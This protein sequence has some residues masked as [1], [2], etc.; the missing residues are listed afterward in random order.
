M[1]DYT[2]FSQLILNKIKYSLLLTTNYL[3]KYC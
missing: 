2:V 1:H 3:L